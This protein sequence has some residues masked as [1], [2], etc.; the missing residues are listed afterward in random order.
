M[1]AAAVVIP[2]ID[3]QKGLVVRAVRGERA[4]Y[5]PV[6]SQLCEGSEPAAVARALL[7][8]TGTSTLYVA[9]LDA[10]TG[11]AAQTAVLRELLHA[12]PGIELWLDAG[13]ADAAAAGALR[14]ALGDAGTRLRPVFGSESL[15]SREALASCFDDGH[16]VLS[17]DRRDGRRLD[18]AGCWEAAELWPQRVIV[19]TLERVGSDAGPDLPTIAEVRAKAPG[20]AVIGAGGVRHAADLLAAG[21]AGADAWLVASALHERRL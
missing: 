12:L 13:F 19:M 20:A 5:R 7:A 11:G 14:D 21:A 16:G 9:D 15:R 6:V 18:A 2:V 10:L 1:M 4:N 17:L 3:L 8:H